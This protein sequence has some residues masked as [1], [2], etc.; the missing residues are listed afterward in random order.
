[1]TVA[2][3]S[4]GCSRRVQLVVQATRE[5]FTL[6]ID[7]RGERG[8]GDLFCEHERKGK[9]NTLTYCKRKTIQNV[10]EKYQK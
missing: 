9:K 6:I 8:G 10:L 3:N 2:C 4:R 5:G 1:V 7:M